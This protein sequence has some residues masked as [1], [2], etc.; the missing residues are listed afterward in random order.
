MVRT[1][2]TDAELETLADSLWK[3]PN[4]PAATAAYECLPGTA[5]AALDEADVRARPA[6]RRAGGGIRSTP[7]DGAA[8]VM[9]RV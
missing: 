4:T 6:R 2:T 3:P 8:R 9:W 1:L 7:A 5:A